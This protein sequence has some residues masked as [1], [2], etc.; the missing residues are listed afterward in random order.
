MIC[1]FFPYHTCCVARSKQ[2]EAE[3]GAGG[4]NLW[5]ISPVEEE[6]PND[7][8]CGIQQSRWRRCKTS[9][10]EEELHTLSQIDQKK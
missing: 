10:T 4:F 2:H 3:V 5:F 6:H 7:C 1:E 9:S 8:Y